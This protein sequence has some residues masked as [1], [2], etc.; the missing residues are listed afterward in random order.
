MKKYKFL[1]FDLDYTLLDFPADMERA[2]RAM[3]TR[4]FAGQQP[5][6]QEL[7]DL[8]E[9]CNNRWWDKF[10]LK[11]CT[12]EELYVNRFADFLAESG[13]SGD[14]AE[15]ND[16]YFDE[17]AQGGTVYPGALEVLDALKDRYELYAVTNG[18]AV[19]AKNRLKNS[20]I[21]KRLRDCF[22]S[23]A[24]GVGK[25]DPA[26]FAYV[27]EHIPGFEKELALVIGDSLSSDILGA[28]RFGLDSVWYHPAGAAEG[29]VKA[30]PTYTVTGYEQLLELLL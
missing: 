12:K 25:P 6:A 26:Y 8:Y 21:G 29:T 2:F 20:G 18:Y 10:E 4:C 9:V 13:L 17:L 11:E 5:Y 22:I 28:N 15:I 24:V 23:E 7:H 16:V 14:P 19:S 3:Y 1:L 30:T 27:A